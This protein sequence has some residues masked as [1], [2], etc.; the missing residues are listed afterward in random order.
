MSLLQNNELNA[1]DFLEIQIRASYATK[2]GIIRALAVLCA[3]LPGMVCCCYT[4]PI[5]S[6]HYRALCA[7]H[8]GSDR[9]NEEV[10]NENNLQIPL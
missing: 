10:N 9:L 1:R 3:A 8:S 7:G 4:T 5:E 6:G 2:P